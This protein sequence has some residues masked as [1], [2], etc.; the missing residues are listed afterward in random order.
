VGIFNKILTSNL[1]LFFQIGVS[2]AVAA[3]PEGLPICVAVTLALGVMRM[4]SKNAI[5]KKLP[6]VEAL[7][8]TNVVC[9]DKTGTLTQNQM[10]VTKI[11]VHRVPEMFVKVFEL[12]LSL[13]HFSFFESLIVF[14]LSNI[15]C[16]IALNGTGYDP[17]IGA[18][19]VDG[20]RATPLTCPA[21]T[22]FV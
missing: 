18:I 2:L 1:F 19:F 5:I 12:F 7:G 9:V 16:S 20:T 14:Y 13:T 3:I 22:R 10:T 21:L 8:C 11:Y 15:G 17:S 4:A 6:A